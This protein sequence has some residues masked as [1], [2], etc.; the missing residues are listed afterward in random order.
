MGYAHIE[1]LY[2]DKNI[3]LFKECYAL[4]KIHG[5]SAHIAWNEGNLTLFSGGVKYELFTKLFD[6]E[7][8]KAGFEKMGH[9]KACIYGEA[10]G[11]KCQ[12]MS[13]TYGKELRFVAFEVSINN[14]FVNVPTAEAI[15]TNTFGLEFVSYERMPCTIEALNEAKEKPSVQAK[16]NGIEGDK[17]REGIV[18]RPLVEAF[19]FGGTKRVICKH[20]NDDFMETGT[21]R[22]VLGDE[23]KLI[24]LESA[25]KI[26]DEWVTEMRLKHVLDKLSCPMDVSSISEVISAMQEDIEREGE[27]EIVM[28]PDARKAIGRKTAVLYKEFLKESLKEG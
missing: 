14:C 7:V 18:C 5:T 10:Y 4:E 23:D 8:L 2:K 19:L 22:P 21:P 25:T 3:L 11:G 26:A 16:R 24:V 28:T 9:K 15:V 6:H 20:K 1:N 17:K 27:G 12:G 13:A